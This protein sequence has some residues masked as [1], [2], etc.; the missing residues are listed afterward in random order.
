VPARPP[1]RTGEV[2]ALRRADEDAVQ[3]LVRICSELDGGVLPVQGP[4]G[5]GKTT[6]GAK[7]IL[8]LAA[9]GKKIGITAVSHKVIDNL[10]VAVRKADNASGQLQHPHL[11]HK[12]DERDDVDG[13]EF[14]KSSG[15]ALD[16]IAPGTI[17]GGTAWLWAHPDAIDRLDVL[18]IDEAGQ[19]ALAQALSAARA[20]RNVVLLGDPQ[21]LEQPRR[22]AHED[23]ADVAALVHLLGPAQ[24]TLSAEQGLFL[25]RT[26][27]LHPAVC[28]FTSEAYYEGRLQSNCGLERQRIEGA[29]PFVGAGLFLVEVT[30][31]DN[32]AQSLEEVGA[33]VAIARSLLQPSTTW[34][35]ADGETRPLEPKD[36]LVVAPYNSQVSALR[37]ALSDVHVVRVGTVDKFQGQEA[38]IVIYSCASSSPEDAPRGMAF[39]YDPH[40]FNVATSRACSTVIVVANPRLFEP[41]CRT[42]EQMVWAN[43]F[44]RFEEMA[45][46]VKLTEA[47]MVRRLQGE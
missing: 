31:E 34:T 39:L 13:V 36:I 21:Q 17:V 29:T 15:E 47:G 25:D 14:A 33:V 2:E 45:V 28:A 27:R 18:V 42:P 30:H 7:A 6:Q 23:G 43:E 5:A 8:A 40:R 11:V 22:G 3:A 9:A 10:L 26:Y 44:C 12:D 24:A 37:R 35:N 32:Q 41:D 46:K 38:P 20:A 16:R 1:R 19:M 4:P